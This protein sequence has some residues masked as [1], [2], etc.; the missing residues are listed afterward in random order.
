MNN[1]NDQLDELEM[2]LDGM[3]SESESNAFLKHYDPVKLKEAQ[4]A[5]DQIDD[6]LRSMFRFD[7]LDS[8]QVQELTRKAFQ[9]DS[10]ASG[11]DNLSPTVELKENKPATR[12]SFALA[13]LT[14]AIL[15]M[16]SV[17]IWLMNDPVPTGPYFENRPVALLY[18]ESVQAGFQPYYRCED[19]QR[20][21]NEFKFRLGKAVNL[22][23]SEMPEGTR[24]LGLSYLGGTSRESI[25][26]L[27]E[28]DGHQVIVFVDRDTA[29]QPDVTTTGTEGLNVFVVERDGFVFTEVSPL[30]ES[31]MIQHLKVPNE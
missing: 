4:A 30:A 21:R 23:K 3:M 6:S 28:V 18:Q 11:I 12:K 9:S 16:V 31:R 27:S 15:A 1:K 14:A 13:A 20:F 29:S 24:M 25:A 5:Q 19:E 10:P 17:G 22:A 8:T 26:M 7:S 2:Y